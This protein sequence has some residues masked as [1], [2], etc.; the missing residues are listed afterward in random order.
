MTNNAAD[1]EAVTSEEYWARKGDVSLFM[2]RRRRITALAGQAGPPVLLVH[3]SSMS[4]LPTFDLDVPGHPDYS[5]MAWLA[6]RGHD[7][8]TLDHEGYGRS[9]ITAGNSDIAAGVDDLKAAVEVICRETGS[10]ALHLYGLS[11]GALRAAAFA[12]RFPHRVARL[13]LD[14]FVWT[15]EGSPTLGKR[16]ENLEFFRAH[17][18]RPIDREFIA[19]IFTRDKPG[20]TDPAVAYACA[21][22]QLAFGDSVPTGS[23]LDMTTKLPLVEPARIVMPTLV[24]RGEHDGIATMEDLAGFFIRL[25]NPD[26]QFSVLPGLAHCTPLGNSRKRLWQ[27]VKDFFDIQ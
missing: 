7:V 15:G 21:D 4:A 27:A 22:A 24:V 16:R 12:E 2:W 25:P 17:N 5:F 18:R 20:T 8:W 23:Y 3:G 6:R 9:T 10:S 26:K 19:S 14:G 1:A 13:V 11:S